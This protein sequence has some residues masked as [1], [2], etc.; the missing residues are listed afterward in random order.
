MAPIWPARRALRRVPLAQVGLCGV[1]QHADGRETL[2]ERVLT[3]TL[4][5]LIAAMIPLWYIRR[6]GWLR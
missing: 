4:L 6:R 1:E 3:T 5:T 2:G